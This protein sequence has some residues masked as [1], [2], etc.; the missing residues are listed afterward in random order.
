MVRKS[1][2][3]LAEPPSVA[4]MILNYNGLRWLP[5]CLASVAG[6]EY[7]NLDVYLVDNGSV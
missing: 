3:R 7:P 6:T 4:I 5:I 1:P 2:V